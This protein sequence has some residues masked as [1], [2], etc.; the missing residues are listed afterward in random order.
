MSTTQPMI[1]PDGSTG[2]IPSSN[3][4]DAIKAGFK[5]ATAVTSPDGKLGY[6]PVEK[7]P[8]AYK[9]GFKPVAQPN[10]PGKKIRDS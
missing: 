9:A 7:T 8:D 5:L 6:I 2:D 1:A 10:P 3:I 4:N